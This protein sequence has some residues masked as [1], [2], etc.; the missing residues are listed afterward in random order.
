MQIVNKDETLEDE[1]MIID[2]VTLDSI[3]SFFQKVE[4]EKDIKE[5]SKNKEDLQLTVFYVDEDS[6]EETLYLYRLWF[7]EDN[8]VTI[9]STN[10][11][12]PYGTLD[13]ESGLKLKNLLIP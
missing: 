12:E 1:E 2:I 13:G 6:K 10:E 11:E 5:E 3:E 8:A 7:H 9:I 4:W